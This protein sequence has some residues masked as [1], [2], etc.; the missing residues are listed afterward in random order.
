[1]QL[2][3]ATGE[4]GRMK[5]AVGATPTSLPTG[6]V[7]YAVCDEMSVAERMDDDAYS[8]MS[9]VEYLTFKQMVNDAWRRELK[10]FRQIA[11]TGAFRRFLN[12]LS[13]LSAQGQQNEVHAYGDSFAGQR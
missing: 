12:W 8:E 1:M 7:V 9:E 11:P 4:P 5:F 10:A 13:S 3:Y 6:A 2:I